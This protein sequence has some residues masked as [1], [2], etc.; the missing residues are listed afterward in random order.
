MKDKPPDHIYLQCYDEDGNLL[1][2]VRDD[3]T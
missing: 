3:V 1:D 2:F